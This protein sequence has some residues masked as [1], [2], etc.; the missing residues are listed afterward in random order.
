MNGRP[1]R[2]LLDTNA[3]VALLQGHAGLG[4]HLSDAE[5]LGISII[6]QLEF[7][8]FPELST[9]DIDHFQHFVQRVNVIGLTPYATTY[10]QTIVR[11][12]QQYRLRLPDAIIAASALEYAATLVTADQQLHG[13]PELSVLDFSQ[14]L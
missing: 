1:G 10:L 4:Q 11:I 6:T 5:W 9:D 8:A 13:V 7:L 14:Q 3:V 2:Y 12:R